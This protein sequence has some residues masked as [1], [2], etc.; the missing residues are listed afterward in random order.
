MGGKLAC[1][2]Q[3]TAV[4]VANVPEEKFEAAVEA[5]KPQTVTQ[6]ADM[7]KRSRIIRVIDR[8]RSLARYRHAAHT[9]RR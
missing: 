9:W 8:D 4:P 2:R 6:L 5:S 1:R 3:V 7:G